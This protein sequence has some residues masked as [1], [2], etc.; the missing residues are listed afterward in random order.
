VIKSRRQ[1][2]SLNPQFNETLA[3]DSVDLPTNLNITAPLSMSEKSIV[4]FFIAF[5]NC[6]FKSSFNFLYPK[7]LSR[8]LKAN[9]NS[10]L[11]RTVKDWDRLTA[12]DL[13][14]VVKF[15]LAAAREA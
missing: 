9:V 4:Q 5:L 14:G 7:M 11:L 8:H 15:P 1:E 10:V 6:D 2:K 13:L 3:F 12:D